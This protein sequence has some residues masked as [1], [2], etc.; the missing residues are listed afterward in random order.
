MF[1]GNVIECP[2]YQKLCVLCFQHIYKCSQF[3]MSQILNWAL[4][5]SRKSPR[6]IKK[7]MTFELT[8]LPVATFSTFELASAFFNETCEYVC[9]AH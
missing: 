5:M 3:L 6:S 1:A 4:C 7:F 2:C 8:I 9:S